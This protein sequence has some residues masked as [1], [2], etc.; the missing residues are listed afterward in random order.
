MTASP[1]QISSAA[2]ELIN[3][4]GEGAVEV[5]AER[6]EL[7]KRTGDTPDLDAALL[8]LGEVEKLTGT[9]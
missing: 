4:H 5:A 7:L 8:V 1:D 2:R 6:V 3:L 9:Q